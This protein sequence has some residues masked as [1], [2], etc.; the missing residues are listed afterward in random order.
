MRRQTS[1][2]ATV[3]GQ[4]VLRNI[5]PI[6]HYQRFNPACLIVSKV[7]ERCWC[8]VACG[9][10]NRYS[11]PSKCKTDFT[12]QDFEQRRRP[13]SFIQHCSPNCLAVFCS[14]GPGGNWTLNPVWILLLLLLSYTGPRA[15]TLPSLAAV[16]LMFCPR[17]LFMLIFLLISSHSS[18]FLRWTP[19]LQHR[20]HSVLEDFS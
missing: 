15:I 14:G 6:N 7:K 18:V 13:V 10:E 16:I 8:S 20:K 11:S 17:V 9:H 2:C 12:C 4:T 3:S 1:S 5:R 19:I